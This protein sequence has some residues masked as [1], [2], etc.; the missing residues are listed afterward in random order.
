M[1]SDGRLRQ[2]NCRPAVTKTRP[3]GRPY[4][5]LRGLGI[6]LLVLLP[7][8][9]RLQASGVQEIV[10]WTGWSG[11]E[12]EIQQGLIEEFNRTHPGIHVRMLT[13]FNSTGSYHKV[14]IAFA[15]GATPDVMSTIL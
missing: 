15:G 7:G 12:Y 2:C 13:Q 14:R 11:H 3:Y 5:R 8:C 6:A 1:D 10:Y 9:A 4:G